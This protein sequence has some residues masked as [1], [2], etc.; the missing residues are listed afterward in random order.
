MG[1]GATANYAGIVTTVL[2]EKVYAI[3]ITPDTFQLS[4]KKEYTSL[5]IAVTFTSAGSGNAHELEFTKKLSKTG[6]I[7][8]LC[9]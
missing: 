1:I 9:H 6:I 2:P 4:S 8:L 3:A 7:L 5:G